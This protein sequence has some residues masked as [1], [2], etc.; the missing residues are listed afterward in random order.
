MD[1]E[2]S[3]LLTVRMEAV[4]IEKDLRAVRMVARSS[5]WSSA[6]PFSITGALAGW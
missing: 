6:I 2:K 4:G 1:S 3:L 5:V